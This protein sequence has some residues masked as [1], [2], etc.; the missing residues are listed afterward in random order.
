MSTPPPQSGGER[1]LSGP[2]LLSLLMARSSNQQVCDQQVTGSSLSGTRLYWC[3]QSWCLSDH[4]LWF[5]PHHRAAGDWPAPRPLQQCGW[6]SPD[7]EHYHCVTMKRFNKLRQNIRF[8]SLRNSESINHKPLA[9]PTTTVYV[10]EQ[11]ASIQPHCYTVKTWVRSW[12]AA[13]SEC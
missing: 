13:V 11:L 5:I 1:T 10:K 2:L 7:S 8:L 12:L 9:P 6:T 3:V 4:G